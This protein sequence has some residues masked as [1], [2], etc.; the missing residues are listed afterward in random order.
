MKRTYGLVALGCLLSGVDSKVVRWAA[1]AREADWR[2]AQATVAVD[3]LLHGTT[4]KPTM[5]PRS[6][7]DRTPD[8]RL[9]K[10]NSTDNTCGYISGITGMSL[11]CVGPSEVKG[12]LTPASLIFILRS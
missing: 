8:Q 7:L 3:Q 4:P 2:P 5:A 12:V 11:S 10:R 6:P 1:N 9:E